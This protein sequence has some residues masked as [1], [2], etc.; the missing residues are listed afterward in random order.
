MVTT[1]KTIII[2]LGPGPQTDK[3]QLILFIVDSIEIQKG[4][5]F[6]QSEGIHAYRWEPRGQHK[7]RFDGTFYKLLNIIYDKTIYIDNN[8]V[9]L[10]LW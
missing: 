8:A 6:V 1:I 3:D 7:W 10:L 5:V 9:I 2:L 4:M